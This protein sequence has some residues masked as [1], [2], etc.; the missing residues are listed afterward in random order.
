MALALDTSA[1]LALVTDSPEHDVV[2]EALAT[3]DTWCASALA[4]AEAL[5]AIDRL[6][7][8]PIYR[9]DIED[10][11]RRCMDYLHIMPVDQAC[12]DTAAQLCRTQPIQLTPAIHLAAASRLPRPTSVVTFDPTQITIAETLGLPVI[13]TEHNK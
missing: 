9:S 4:L 10:S 8:T 5:P 7:D 2:V 1:L 12:L 6:T 3:D 11:L 13:S